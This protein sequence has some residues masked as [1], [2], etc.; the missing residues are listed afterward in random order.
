MPGK[1][2]TTKLSTHKTSSHND[3]GAATTTAKKNS[4]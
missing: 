4:T 3:I 1:D 2:E